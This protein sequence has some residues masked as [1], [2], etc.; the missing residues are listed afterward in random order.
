MCAV[1]SD[2]QNWQAEQVH[3]TVYKTKRPYAVP[4]LFAYG[5]IRGVTSNVGNKGATSDGIGMFAKTA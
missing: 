1:M 5:D 4:R 2:Q 3:K